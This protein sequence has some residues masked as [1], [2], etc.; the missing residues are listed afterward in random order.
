MDKIIKSLGS[1]PQRGPKKKPGIRLKRKLTGGFMR[2]MTWTALLSIL[3]LL[4][5]EVAEIGL[6]RSCPRLYSTRTNYK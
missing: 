2:R 3:C 6:E 5:H 4:I 1:D